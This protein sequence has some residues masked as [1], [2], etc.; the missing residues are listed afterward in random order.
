VEFKQKEVCNLLTSLAE[1]LILK[2]FDTD[3]STVGYVTEQY[4]R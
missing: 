4:W 3:I 2:L 1:S